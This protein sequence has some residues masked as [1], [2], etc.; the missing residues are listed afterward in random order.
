[1]NEL[2]PNSDRLLDTIKAESGLS[3][4]QIQIW[5]GQKVHPE[6]PFCNMAFAIV[7]E[8]AI[9]E[10]RF[11]AAWLAAIEEDDVL[12]SSIVETQGV[13]KLETLSPE[14]CPTHIL[15]F[16]TN[17]QPEDS[18]QK[19][20]QERAATLLPLTGPL[21]ESILVKLAENRFGW[22]L[23]Q[24]HIIMDASAALLL[25]N[26]VS[27]NY[28]GTPTEASQERSTRYKELSQKL[29][30][31]TSSH[32]FWKS[33]NAKNTERRTPIYGRKGDTQ[34]TSSTRIQIT[35]S[36][37]QSQSIRE[38]AKHES[39]ASFF[40]EI[41]I[42]TIFSSLLAAFLRRTGTQ[43]RISFDS[44][45]SNRPSREAKS[46]L[47]CFIEMFPLD[48]PFEKG[49]TF[50]TL[51]ERAMAE[52]GDFLRNAASGASSPD[53]AS[54]SNVVLNYF[55]SAFEPFAGLHVKT[56][57]IHSQ[58]IDG[59]YDLK[60]QVHD[61]NNS[62]SYVIQFDVSNS[63][64]SEY[65]QRR[66]PEHFQCLLDA[67]LADVNSEIDAIDILTREERS[68]IQEDFNLPKKSSDSTPSSLLN[69]IQ[70]QVVASPDSIALREGA[71]T[72]TYQ[73]LWDKSQNAAR[74]LRSI[75]V[76]EK[77]CVALLLP[78]SIEL[79]VA[80]I[81]VLRAGSAYIPIDPKYPAKRIDRI[82]NDSE[83]K[84]VIGQGTQPKSLNNASGWTT[85]EKLE[86]TP[87]NLDLPQIA[88]NSLAYVIYTSGSTGQ[89]KG[90]EIEH[91]GLADYICWAERTYVRGRTLA[92]PLFT[93][94]AFDLTVTSIFLPLISGGE[95]IVYPQLN[96]A[97]DHGII[98]V[99]NEN[100][101]DF[102]KLTPSHLSLLRNLDLK[103]SRL[104]CLVLGGEDLKQSLADEVTR[105]FDK[106]I[107]LYNEYGPTEAVVGCMIHR[108]TG[109][110]AGGSVPIGKPSDGVSIHLLNGSGL[111]VP[112]GTSGEIYIERIGLARGYRN[113]PEKT[114]ASFTASPIHPTNRSYKTGDLARFSEQGTI[115]YLGR[116]D[117]QIKRSGF[118]VELGEIEAALALHPQISAAHVG[119]VEQKQTKRQQQETAHCV[120]CGISSQYP[121]VVFNEEGVC[122]ICASYETI[123]DEA[124]AYFKS[125]HRLQELFDNRRKEK[126][127]S[128][129][130]MV[131]FSGGKDS[132]YALCKLVDM[133]LKVYAFTLD[134]GYLSEQA[135]DNVRR[136]TEELGVDH[137][138]ARTEAM[139]EIFRDSLTRFSNVCNGCF[140][141][142]YTLGIN[143]AHELGIP[144][145][146][147]GLSR[148]QFFETR[149]TENLFINGKFS[150]E[151][152]DQAV[153]E[154]RKTY[155]RT[156]DA[157]TR[158]LDN[159]LFQD[160]AI[161]DE[162]LFVDFYR[163]WSAPLEEIY[164]YLAKRVPWI[165]PS[166]TGRS[167]NC[168]INDVGIYIHNKERGYHN[169]ALPYS[170]DVR[171]D[172]KERDEAK[173]ELNDQFDLSEVKQMLAEI[174][175][176]ENRLVSNEAQN[177]LVAYY[178][179]PEAIATSE[180]IAT[181]D[182]HL[183]SQLRPSHFVHLENMPLT[184][185]GKIDVNALP[186][187]EPESETLDIDHL[188]P[189]G[190]VEEHVFEVW[191]KYLG[192]RSFGVDDSFFQI[193]GVSLA[194]MEIT[195]QLCND[196]EIDLPLQ[197]IF[198]FS[199]VTQLSQKIEEIIL[200]EIEA[201]SSDEV[202][203][204]LESDS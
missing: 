128:Y 43:D 141:T 42:Y 56:D 78:R 125:P 135:M 48:F 2:S 19:L 6:S 4:S 99:I 14:T 155:H 58:H 105:E 139:N 35:L 90:V 170:W 194:A 192:T 158:C 74:S 76:D 113:D 197:S 68:R 115:T 137:E 176:D 41:S 62:G 132:A 198:Q 17:E 61:Y 127:P 100:A 146:V 168:R 166:D 26:A 193:G 124:Q 87:P 104:S 159:S 73:N 188:K 36:E 150:P 174:G 122:G 138:F 11:Q 51:G 54:V 21:L 96:D 34:D 109:G 20:A 55:P 140:K 47:G 79:I 49:D 83:A 117:S 186:A 145:I 70:S 196:F 201:M 81:G 120:K 86:S 9:D 75:G 30:T 116:I 25:F 28:A 57:W 195:L 98:D 148:G 182:R 64:F 72:L 184:A 136:V 164:S 169:Y 69:L 126:D 46:C 153:L 112:E 97:V 162:I 204:L 101:V 121:S 190:E 134:N 147:T 163:Y 3:H 52:I 27:R 183:P 177:A 66:I 129:D 173:E 29:E 40:P 142:I 180:L 144:T 167:T 7:I 13:P 171:L 8:G 60:L 202:D 111:P 152:V 131:F 88:P 91:E 156:E 71:Q 15:D 23:N 203:R 16:S 103:N 80:I 108:H 130:C 154:A 94:V 82:L 65:D 45:A 39:F 185:N 179:A 67:M 200:S 114:A 151:Q 32:E 89:P 95:L 119:L 33:K 10:K 85:L 22:L 181:A 31:T 93:S 118:R 24:H 110:Y 161:F 133:G 84:V 77:S 5:T 59:V 92:Y 107:E 175:Y 44:P 123:K 189:N 199:T 187:I 165:R 37:S 38:L 50:A 157:A 102:I 106:S 63:T 191:A 178:A 12:L 160:D 18:F 172:Q 149:L 53:G 143:R 1:M